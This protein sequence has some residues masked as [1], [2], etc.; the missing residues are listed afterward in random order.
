MLYLIII[1]YHYIIHSKFF[2]F[3]VAIII[4]QRVNNIRTK[5]T[6]L[7]LIINDDVIYNMFDKMHFI[8]FI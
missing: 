2:F 7:N 6:I 4:A 8:F 5:Y 1:F 3:L